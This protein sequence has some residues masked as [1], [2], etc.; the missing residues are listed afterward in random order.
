MVQ[1]RVVVSMRRFEMFQLGNFYLTAD[2]GKSTYASKT[3]ALV[4]LTGTD[5]KCSLYGKFS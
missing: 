4:T 3:S 5:V 1:G 2:T